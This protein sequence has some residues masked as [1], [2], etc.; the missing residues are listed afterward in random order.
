MRS[1]SH[2]KF[3]QIAVIPAIGVRLTGMTIHRLMAAI[4]SEQ[5]S[6]RGE[7][8]PTQTTDDRNDAAAEQQ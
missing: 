3:C 2:E 6:L 7:D 1:R 8:E 4:A 5:V